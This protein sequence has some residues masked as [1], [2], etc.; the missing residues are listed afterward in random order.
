MHFHVLG[1]ALLLIGGVSYS[2]YSCWY[3]SIVDKL[4][5]ERNITL[6]YYLKGRKYTS[7]STELYASV[8][9]D[10]SQVYDL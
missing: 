3:C 4:E 10:G 2:C 8:S 6:I 5:G 9:V 1:K 7:I